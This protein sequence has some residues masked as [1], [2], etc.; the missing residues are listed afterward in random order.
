MDKEKW[1]TKLSQLIVPTISSWIMRVWFATIKTT[2]HDRHFRDQCRE[3]EQAI[4]LTIWHNAIFYL[5]YHIRH[6]PGVAL[7]SSSRDGEYVARIA[8][9]FGFETVRGSRNRRGMVAL[10]KLM[11][12]IQ[13]GRNVGIVADGSQGPPLVVQPGSILL[14]SKSGAPIL[15]VIWSS[16]NYW[17]VDSWDRTILPKPFSRLEFFYGE[18]LYVEKGLKSRNL[19]QYRQKLEKRMAALYKASWEFQ[20]KTG[21]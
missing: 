6:S 11:K 2:E 9:R 12:A 20:G 18:P 8:E 4:I 19:E 21:H 1:T 14:A 16:S 13:D 10:K 17:V 5:F 3:H 7:V 15:P